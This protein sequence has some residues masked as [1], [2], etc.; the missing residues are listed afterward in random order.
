MQRRNGAKFS[1]PAV[2]GKTICL[3]AQGMPWTIPNLVLHD[4]PVR[5]ANMRTHGRNHVFVNCGNPDCHHNAEIDVSGFADNV[6]YGDL[7]P[8]MLCTVCDHRGAD[9]GPSWLHRG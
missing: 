1:T 5:L 2:N 8:R 4:K 6:T 3:P 9:V 7:Q